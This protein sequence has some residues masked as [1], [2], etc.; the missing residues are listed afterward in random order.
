M[1]LIW[2]LFSFIIAIGIL[3][4]V[5]EFGHFWVARRCG[6]RVDTFSIGF[7]KVLFKRQDKTGTVF[8]ISAI[9]LG[10][11]VKMLDGRTT[12]LTDENRQFA[13]DQKTILQRA[14]IVA[15][16]PVANFLFA[17]FVYCA[18]FMLGVPT[19]PAKIAQIM[20]DSIVSS[21]KITAGAELKSIAGI[22]VESWQDVR[23]ALVN[24]LGSAKIQVEYQPHDQH[25]VISTELNTQRWQVDLEKE[26]PAKSLGFVP[27]L[28]KILP[29]VNQ[30]M[31]NSAAEKAGFRA[32]DEIIRVNDETL[33][34][35]ALFANQVKASPNQ[36]LN[37][38]ILRDKTPLTVSLIP[39]AKT[40]LD[41]ES[42]GF[43]GI[44][45][46]SNVII[47]QYGIVDA[48]VKGAKMTQ[49]MIKTTVKS[50]WLLLTGVLGLD[51][52]SG[53]VT[54]AKV[55]GESATQG[56]VAFLGFLG[57]ISISLGVVNL[58]PLPV[59]DGGHLLLLLVEKIKGRPVSLENQAQFYR[60]GLILL[61]VLM[62]LAL[63]NDL[64]RL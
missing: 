56:I 34:T 40:N 38:G 24:A 12:E 4:W 58:L 35:W 49:Q 17:I 30:V 44:V 16:G 63:F 48:F 25:H 46:R 52:L 57:F 7:G 1:S 15:A 59:L 53:P 14:L 54:I 43:A 3:V 51:N 5:H 22:K 9:P 21:T 2:T 33:V 60:F 37:I 42:E 28:P 8:A 26:D 47:Q 6:V 32:G 29:I 64:S 10:G 31:P 19:Y 62:G 36:L 20:P 27:E 18:V 55:A 61:L 39:E 13:F 50:F 41:G 23:L 11:Y 45:P